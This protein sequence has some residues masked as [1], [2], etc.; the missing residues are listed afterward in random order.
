M[1]KATLSD[2]DL[3]VIP[4]STIAELIDE[5]VFNISKDK[6]SL[7]AADR[8]MVAAVDFNI[9][10][11]AFDSYELEKETSIGLNISNLLSV[12]KRARSKDKITLSLKDSK[13]EIFLHNSTKRRFVVPLIEISQEEVPSIEQLQFTVKVELKPEILRESIKDAEIVSDAITFEASP[14]SFIMRAEGDISQT[15]SILEKG[16][17]DLLELDAKE[18]VKARYPIDYLKKMIKAARLA[19]SV[20]IEFAQ[21][22][23]MKL[24]F[25]VMDKV[26]LVFVL[27]PR[28]LEE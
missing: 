14:K 3:L 4:I 27:A 1:F 11:T 8:A 21:E 20:I 2:P 26:S 23:P 15:E 6:I 19:D 16:N 28:V 10:A 5:G 7:I 17:E 18:T 13:F 22:Y 9:L 24:S 25:K 12:L